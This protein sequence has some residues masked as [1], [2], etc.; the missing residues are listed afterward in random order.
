MVTKTLIIEHSTRLK[1]GSIKMGEWCCN[2]TE[3]DKIKFNFPVLLENCPKKYSSNLFYIYIYAY[4]IYRE[5]E[6]NSIKHGGRNYKY[7]TWSHYSL[8]T[9]W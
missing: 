7:D 8:Y 5:Y 3:W 1:D 2:K 9:P 4:S 6:N